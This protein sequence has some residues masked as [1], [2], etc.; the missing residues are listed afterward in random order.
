MK[1]NDTQI[2]R[3]KDETPN[4]GVAIPTTNPFEI[5]AFLLPNGARH[6]VLVD[7]SETTWETYCN[8][9]TENLP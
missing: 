2:R 7:E 9:I 6:V 8:Q 1:L 3:I 4:G 5:A